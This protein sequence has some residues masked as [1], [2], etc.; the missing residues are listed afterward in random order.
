M[1]RSVNVILLAGKDLAYKLR[2]ASSA[3]DF[4]WVWLSNRN[5]TG[6]DN[7]CC[8]LSKRS[9]KVRYQVRYPAHNMSW[10]Y[11]TDLEEL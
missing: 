4:T 11:S 3:S 7:Q 2:T 1:I 10:E 9:P 6:P 8:T 5:Y